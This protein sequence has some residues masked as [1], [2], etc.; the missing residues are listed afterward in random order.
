M[1]GIMLG[2][3][4]LGIYSVAVKL[5]ELWYFIPGII[6]GSVLPAIISA[7]SRDEKLYKARFL[8]LYTILAWLAICLAIP[9]SIF[10]KEIIILLYGPEYVGAALS[11]SI[12]IWAGVG[13][14]L[15]T[16]SSQYLVIEKKTN[17]SLYRSIIGMVI[18]FGLNLILI[19]LL[20][21]EGAA[22]S[23]FIAYTLVTF[24]LFIFKDTREH[25][26][27]FFKAL[28]PKSLFNL[29]K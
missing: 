4:A 11:L 2:E 20:G 12:S 19:P 21:I 1:I 5:A 13:V 18:N 17:L 24:S 22:I 15:G 8:K 10:S 26:I 25:S 9:V 27:L 28:S 6:V 3:T 7:K 23:T 29:I 16:A 14:F